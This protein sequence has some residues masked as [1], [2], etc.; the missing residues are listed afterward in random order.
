MGNLFFTEEQLKRLEEQEGVAKKEEPLKKIEEQDEKNEGKSNKPQKTIWATVFL[1]ILAIILVI[2]FINGSNH[3]PIEKT[4]PSTLTV[5]KNTS[6]VLADTK[7]ISNPDYLKNPSAYLIDADSGGSELPTGKTVWVEEILASNLLKIS[8]PIVKAGTN[9]IKV[10][11]LQIPG[12]EWLEKYDI[13]CHADAAKDFMNKYL[14]HTKIFVQKERSYESKSSDGLPRLVTI[15]KLI[16]ANSGGR[17]GS[18][19]TSFIIWNGFGI[20]RFLS[21]IEKNYDILQGEFIYTSP[22]TEDQRNLLD[23]EDVAK[24]AKRGFWGTCQYP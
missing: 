9:I 17:N 1:V 20:I 24:L 19:V 14:L 22:G 23:Q 11:T 2:V 6:P 8:F 21:A 12:L 7:S 5:P 13:K 16:M 18:D 15:G 10:Q 4:S 3:V